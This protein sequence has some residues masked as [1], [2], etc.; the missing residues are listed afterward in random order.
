MELV[1]LLELSDCFGKEFCDQR[2]LP[3][4][5]PSLL[6]TCLAGTVFTSPRR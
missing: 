5:R 2:A 6:K 4:L 3:R 1:G